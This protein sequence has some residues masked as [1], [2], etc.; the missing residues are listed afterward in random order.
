MAE[1][2]NVDIVE[3]MGEEKN[4]VRRLFYVSNDPQAQ[5]LSREPCD[6]K[7]SEK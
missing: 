6:E 4:D 5:T 1:L 7:L 3:I 2:P